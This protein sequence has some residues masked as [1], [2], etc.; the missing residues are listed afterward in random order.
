MAV[1]VVGVAEM[2]NYTPRELLAMDSEEWLITS[3][4]VAE[5]KAREQAE[6]EGAMR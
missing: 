5:Y 6:A 4:M 3:S 2:T 1:A